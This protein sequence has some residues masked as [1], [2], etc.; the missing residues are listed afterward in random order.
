MSA[1]GI[2]S[3][4]EKHIAA[5]RSNVA[6]ILQMLGITV[7]RPLPVEESEPQRKRRR[8][9]AGQQMTAPETEI[10][11]A[12]GHRKVVLDDNWCGVVRQ[13]YTV[14]ERKPVESRCIKLYD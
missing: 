14:K 9:Y 5:P 3:G 11:V 1:Q 2:T 6:K 4:A 7:S 8:H 13:D 12:G 10:T